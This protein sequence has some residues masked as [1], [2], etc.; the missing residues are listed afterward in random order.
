MVVK[1]TVNYSN[2]ITVH[3]SQCVINIVE[4]AVDV[5]VF[6]TLVDLCPWWQ[7]VFNIKHLIS[8]VVMSEWCFYI[9]LTLF[10]LTLNYCTLS[11]QTWQPLCWLQWQS[12]SSYKCSFLWGWFVV[13]VSVEPWLSVWVSRSIVWACHQYDIE[14]FYSCYMSVCTQ[15]FELQGCFLSV[16][17]VYHLCFKCNWTYINQEQTHRNFVLTYMW[18]LCTTSVEH[19]ASV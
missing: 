7:F 12:V 9:F 1:W 18:L 13:C 2:V 8:V 10:Y 14:Q 11:S 16:I 6:Y 19:F 17:V 15:L 3:C 5:L 4:V